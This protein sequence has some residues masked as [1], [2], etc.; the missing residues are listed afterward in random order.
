MK[1]KDVIFNTINQKDVLDKENRSLKA[2]KWSQ[3]VLGRSK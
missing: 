1:R 2:K 3:T